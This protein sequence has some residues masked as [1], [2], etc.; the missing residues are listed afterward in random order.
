M[1]LPGASWRHAFS[2]K[3]Q[4]RGISWPLECV[5]CWSYDNWTEPVWPSILDSKNTKTFSGKTKRFS[6]SFVWLFWVERLF[7]LEVKTFKA[8]KKRHHWTSM[9][10]FGLIFMMIMTSERVYELCSFQF[11]SS[12][13]PESMQ[14]LEN[15]E[16]L[17]AMRQRN[18]AILTCSGVFSDAKYPKKYSSKIQVWKLI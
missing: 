16:S 3:K 14:N 12:E 6:L 4:F 1:L 7:Y 18:M 15:V 13:P 8:G 9:N 10:L 2:F 11:S 17:E 5:L